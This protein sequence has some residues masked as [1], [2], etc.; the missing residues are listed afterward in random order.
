MLV[1][2]YF[3]WITF[4]TSYYPLKTVVTLGVFAGLIGLSSKI[5]FGKRAQLMAQWLGLASYLIY[6]L[7]EHVGMAIFNLVQAHGSPNLGV[8][9]LT[10]A[11]S[12]TVIC[13]LLALYIEKPLQRVIN[14]GLSKSRL[15]VTGFV[16][17]R[18]KK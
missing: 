16:A 14:R 3:I 8:T 13:V 9:L 6:L 5:T 15:V 12:I 10:T 4:F 2:A 1:S 17:S 18:F 7:H 11:I